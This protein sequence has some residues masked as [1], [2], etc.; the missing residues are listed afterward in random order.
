MIRIILGGEFRGN[1]TSWYSL[2][3]MFSTTRDHVMIYAGGSIVWEKFM[4]PH[5]FVQTSI[6]QHSIFYRSTHCHKTRYISQWSAL[7]QTY[8]AFKHEFADTDVVVKARNDLEIYDTVNLTCDD[9]TLYVP[10]KEFHMNVPFDIETVC[11][12]QIVIGRKQTMDIYFQL[13][14]RYQW[15]DIYSIS[16]EEI[17]RS[18][19]RQQH[20][21]VQTFP[22]MYT[23]VGGI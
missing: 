7:Y 19:I 20:I 14:K 9:N 18:Y 16:V 3:R 5:K 10:E 6:D 22:L 11:N 15:N 12:D 8:E 1:E 17:L 4:I 13:P 2:L 21:D 23:K